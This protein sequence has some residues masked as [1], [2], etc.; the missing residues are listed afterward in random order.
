M[1]SWVVGR[2]G[3]LGHEIAAHAPEVFEHDRID[4]SNPDQARAGL[5][6]AYESFQEAAAAN[7]WSIYW[8]AGSAVVASSS[9]SAE[10][11]LDHLSL[12]LTLLSEQPPAG[13]GAFFLAS[14]A[15]GVYAGSGGAPFNA[16]TPPRPLS[17][18]GWLKLQQEALAAEALDGRAPLVIGR[19]GNLYGSRQDPSKSQGLVFSLCRSAVL[20]QPLNLYVPMQTLRDY[21]NAGD[22]GRAIVRL[23]E[24]ARVDRSVN[25]TTHVIASGSPVTVASL[26]GTVQDVTHRKVPLALGR[27]DSSRHQVIDLRLRPSDSVLAALHPITPLPAGIRNLYDEIVR[28]H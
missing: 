14:S 22:A 15:G 25:V 3:L 1:T 7:P 6:L 20:R 28:A 5:T 16:D 11:E 19:I 4:W 21:I 23:T 8:A 12:L 13:P 18:Y 26:I 10:V 27:N 24:Q 17:P 9:E 2:G